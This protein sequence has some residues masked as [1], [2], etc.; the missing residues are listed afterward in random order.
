MPALTFLESPLALGILT[1][2]ITLRPSMALDSTTIRCR[3]T[4]VTDI[5]L[6]KDDV[7]M[8]W[9]D[10]GTTFSG[11]FAPSGT[12][13]NGAPFPGGWLRWNNIG[14]FEVIIF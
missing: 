9:S 4:D 8:Q 11:D 1:M 12:S 3:R 14:S 2:V 13:D 5:D 6:S 10:G 7:D